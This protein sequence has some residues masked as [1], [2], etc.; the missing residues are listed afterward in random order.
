[1][2]DRHRALIYLL[3][4]GSLQDFE[5]LAQPGDAPRRQEQQPVCELGR[6]VEIVGDQDHGGPL[7]AIESPNECCELD[8]VVQIEMG[9]GLVEEQEARLLR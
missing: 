3:D 5:G 9:V 1:M 7:L 8:L 4:D 2:P 6:Q